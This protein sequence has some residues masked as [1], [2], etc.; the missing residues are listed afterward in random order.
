MFSFFGVVLQLGCVEVFRIEFNC[1]YCLSFLRE[2]YSKK[3]ANNNF[4]GQ[5]IGKSVDWVTTHRQIEKTD[6]TV[7]SWSVT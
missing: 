3:A 2:Y 4:L 7:F 5:Y 1:N 6:V